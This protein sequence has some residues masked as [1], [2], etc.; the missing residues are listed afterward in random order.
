MREGTT[1]R[2]MVADKPYGEFY[3][4]YSVS[5]EYFWH[6]LVILWLHY[7]YSKAAS[8]STH[9]KL[10]AF[11]SII[12]HGH[13]NYIKRLENEWRLLERLSFKC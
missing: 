9:I 12:K 10:H 11:Y 6:N 2:V 13:S 7:S 8:S 1:S 5:P 3:D 4:F